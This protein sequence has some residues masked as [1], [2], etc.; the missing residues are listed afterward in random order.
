MPRKTAKKTVSND[1][2]VSNSETPDSVDTVETPETP[3]KVETPE[4]PKAPIKDATPETP[5][6]VEAIKPGDLANMTSSLPEPNQNA[7]DAWKRREGETDSPKGDSPSPKKGSG[8]M[9]ENGKEEFD[10]DFHATDKD[11]KPIPTKAGGFRKKPGRKSNRLNSRQIEN[12]KNRDKSQAEAQQAEA[13]QL[14]EQCKVSAF[15][16]TQATC[17][18][19][20]I[21]LAIKPDEPEKKEL[22]TA[23]EEYYKFVGPTKMPPWLGPVLVSGAIISNHINEEAPK[24]RIEKIKEWI[25]I[26]IH[27]WKQRRAKA[28]E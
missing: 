1:E 7:I 6:D 21:G 27:R 12:D 28:K 4:T 3:E 11:G 16:S 24:T 5:K 22:F 17:F 25:G 19:L 20:G 10:P 26:R 13:E 9:S 18:A 23:Y 14:A 15:A 8:I 2:G